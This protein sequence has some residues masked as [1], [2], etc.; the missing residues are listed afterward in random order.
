MTVWEDEFNAD[1]GMKKSLFRAVRVF[2]LSYAV[3]FM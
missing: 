2:S 3:T 1:K